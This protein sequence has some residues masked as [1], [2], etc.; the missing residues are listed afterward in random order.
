MYL[1]Y[2]LHLLQLLWIFMY[3]EL[4]SLTYELNP[5]A[6]FQRLQAPV[7]QVLTA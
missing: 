4:C 3:D 2:V 1:L 5:F 7:I 6:C